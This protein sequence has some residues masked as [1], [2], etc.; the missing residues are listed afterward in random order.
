[1]KKAL[2][3]IA[4]SG[5]KLVEYGTS[6]KILID[7][8]IQVITASNLPGTATSSITND[9]A[10]VDL[11]LDDINAAD[12]DGIFFIGGPGALENLDN[13]KSYRIIREVAAS[14]KIWGAIC[15]SPRIL[16]AAGVLKN[17][18]VTGWDKDNELAGILAKAG[19][20]YVR[21]PVVADENLI[22]GNGPEAAEEWGTAIAHA[23]A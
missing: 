3:I 2:L 17:K 8:G 18:K 22:T 23:L 19:A 10:S 13:E 11:V 12:Y 15:I 20:E 6:K 21:K 7:A 5:F 4:H 14:G 1:M 9:K 16:A